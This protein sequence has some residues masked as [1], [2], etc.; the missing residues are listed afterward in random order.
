KPP[1][2]DTKPNAYNIFTGE[3]SQS[4]G[5][6]MHFCVFTIVDNK[7]SLMATPDERPSHLW[8][9]LTFVIITGKPLR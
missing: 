7:Y 3:Y 1:R 6:F 9:P 5:M 2:K 4:K 8:Q